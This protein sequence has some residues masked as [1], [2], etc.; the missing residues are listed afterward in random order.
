MLRR[1]GRSVAPGIGAA[2]GPVA[3]HDQR[4]LSMRWMLDQPPY[5]GPMPNNLRP[6]RSCCP[7]PWHLEQTWCA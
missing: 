5:G 3:D 1:E 2:T 7:V 4:V 6:N